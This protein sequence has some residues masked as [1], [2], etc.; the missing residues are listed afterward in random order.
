MNDKRKITELVYNVCKD[1]LD[2]NT[3]LNKLY[4]EWWVTRR[5]GNGLRLSE[6]GMQAFSLA[7]IAYYEFD[8]NVDTKQ[9]LADL[10]L[11][12]NKKIRCPFYIGFKNRSVKSAYIRIYDSKIATL[13]SLYGNIEEYLGSI[14]I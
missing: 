9:K 3:D 2:K 7:E 4:F 6:N 5:S 1:K 13:V 11:Q 10:I 14:K 8:I 12:S